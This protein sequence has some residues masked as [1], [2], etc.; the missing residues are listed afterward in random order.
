MGALEEEGV[1]FLDSGVP[2]A[3]GLWSAC[4]VELLAPAEPGG[5]RPR[6]LPVESSPLGI[7][8]GGFSFSKLLHHPVSHSCVPFQGLGISAEEGGPPLGSSVT[9]LGVETFPVTCYFCIL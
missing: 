9:D 1:S 2:H 5:Q 4:R 8:L 3:P 6:T 7:P